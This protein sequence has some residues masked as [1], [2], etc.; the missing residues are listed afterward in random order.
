MIA[1]E[2]RN[3]LTGAVQFTAQIECDE[4]TSVSVK[5]GLAVKWGFKSGAYLCGANLRGADLSSHKLAAGQSLAML[6]QPDGW[7][8]FTYFT[9][10]GQQRVSIGCQDKTIA[11]GRVY[12]ANKSDRQEVFA[13][14]DYAEAIARA[15][16]WSAVKA[17]AAE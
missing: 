1:Y 13:C 15:R 2:V 11:E 12:W 16:G 9:D 7:F 10:K 5:I 8:A 17:E 14:L 3:R 6:G 4:N